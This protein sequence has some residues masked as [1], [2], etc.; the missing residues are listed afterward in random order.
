MAL[1]AGARHKER[2]ANR[3]ADVLLLSA[4]WKA[5]RIMANSEA[6]EAPVI[7][8]SLLL[9]AQSFLTSN[10]VTFQL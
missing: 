3:Q 6:D 2:V 5:G 9:V 1:A 10:N 7:R 8:V 4:Q